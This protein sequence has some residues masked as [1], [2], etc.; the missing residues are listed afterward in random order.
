MKLAQ[1]IHYFNWHSDENYSRLIQVCEKYRAAM[2][3]LTLFSGYCHHGYNAIDTVEKECQILS[4]RIS[5]LKKRGFRSVGINV[6]VTLG[7]IDEG[8]TCFEQ[9]FT[10]ITGFDGQQSRSCLCPVDQDFKKYISEKYI[11]YAKTHPDFI[12]VDDDIKLFYNG[13]KFGCFCPTC[14]ERFNHS[15]GTDYTRETL[16]TAIEVPEAI[17]LRAAWVQDTSNKLTELFGLIKTAVQSVDN[18]I[19]LG[20]MT[21]HQ[22]WSTYNGMSFDDWFNALDGCKGRP[23]EGFYE[24]SVPENVCTKALSTSRQAS[25]FPTIVTDR[26]YEV[27]NFPYNLFQKSIRVILDECTLAIAQGMNGVLLN[28]LKCNQNSRMEELDPLYNKI[29]ARRSVWDRM[30]SFADGFHTRGFYPAISANYDK[31]RPLHDGQSFF[32]TYDEAPNHNVMQ[33]YTLCHIGVP[34]TM[35]KEAAAG[36]ILTGD[37]PD[38][39][40]D[41]ELKAFFSKSVIMDGPALRAIERRGL[42]KYAGVRI[43]GAASDGISEHFNMSDPINEGLL[44]E[45]RDIRVAFFGGEGFILEKLD[46]S[47]REISHLETYT[48]D[49]LGLTTSLYENSLGGRVCVLGYAAYKKVDSLSR[50]TQLM[51]ICDYLT[52][53]KIPAKILDARKAAQ[54]IRTSEDGKKILLSIINLSIDDTGETRVAIYGVKQARLL[55]DNGKEILLT[56]EHDGDYAIFTLPS[57][58]PYDMQ[59]L[60]AE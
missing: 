14:I 43:N 5:D 29:I 27:E 40:T 13:V 23:G 33:T 15:Q 57:T 18:T 20:F 1:R 60:L 3:E 56:A 22:G 17:A 19:K 34:L 28:T 49:Q 8:Y 48:G 59:I 31:R 45:Y 50:R 30:N 26:Q 37:L 32:T 46:P 6:L 54:F 51:R 55:E 44:D 35:D 10:P 38:G 52:R 21:Q 2:D 47:V 36:V 4:D 11:L 24:D 9:P 39:F 12:W 7:H 58:A 53:E 16:V 41:E 42:G 25:E